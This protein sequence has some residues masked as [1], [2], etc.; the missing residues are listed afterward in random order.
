MSGSEAGWSFDAG[1]VTSPT[2]GA[3]SLTLHENHFS[4]TPLPAP[5]PGAQSDLPV[6]LEAVLQLG[7]APGSTAELQSAPSL[8]PGTPLQG[9]LGQAVS[10]LLHP[11]SPGELV[12]DRSF[13]RSAA[14][15]AGVDRHHRG[16]P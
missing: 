1:Y 16:G 5:L 15:S 3:P 7:W 9:P 12:F 8:G 10:S 2:E 14:W 6:M 11:T 4:G 13:N